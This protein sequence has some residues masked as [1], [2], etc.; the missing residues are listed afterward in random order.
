PM[1]VESMPAVGIPAV[2]SMLMVP[3]LVLQ[4]F[5]RVL[6]TELGIPVVE[7][8]APRIAEPVAATRQPAMLN[9]M[10]RIAPPAGGQPERPMPAIPRPGLIPLEYYCQR[11]SSAPARNI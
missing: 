1:A 7:M 11:I 2:A 4:S 5:H 9:P 3:A 8:P 10:S 6:K